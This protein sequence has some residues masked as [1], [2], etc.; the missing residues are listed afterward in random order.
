MEK[1]FHPV[2]SRYRRHKPQSH[3]KHL[4]SSVIMAVKTIPHKRTCR[5]KDESILCTT[6]FY[7]HWRWEQSKFKMDYLYESTRS[8]MVT[9]F[10]PASSHGETNT[11]HPNPATPYQISEY[12]FH[13]WSLL[14]LN[15]N[16]RNL[17]NIKVKVCLRWCNKTQHES[18]PSLHQA[19]WEGFFS[20]GATHK[21][22]HSFATKCPL[23][24]IQLANSIHHS[25]VHSDF[26]V[27]KVVLCKL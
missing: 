4:S 13:A 24:S 18:A 27:P 9:S 1:I 20:L 15:S 22:L 3:L 19:Q 16:Q 10:K 11:V 26:I 7:T 2:L 25:N 5:L 23:F 21:I 12:G 17:L 8:Q 6:K 14:D